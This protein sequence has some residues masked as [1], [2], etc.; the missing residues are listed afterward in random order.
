MVCQHLNGAELGVLSDACPFMREIIL[1]SP[2]LI[3]NTLMSPLDWVFGSSDLEEVTNEWAESNIRFKSVHLDGYHH[4]EML[5]FLAKKGGD[6]TSL[7]LGPLVFE[8][9]EMLRLCPNLRY[10]ST[11][12]DDFEVLEM[13]ELS[14]PYLEEY[15]C[16]DVHCSTLGSMSAPNLKVLIIRDGDPVHRTRCDPYVRTEY[17]K[18]AARKFQKLERLEFMMPDERRLQGFLTLNLTQVSPLIY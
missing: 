17:I 15:Y 3:N 14:F 16:Q 18:R 9:E 5:N 7:T 10:L 13:A 4:K 11:Y 12:I 6:L 2:S 1:G 8:F